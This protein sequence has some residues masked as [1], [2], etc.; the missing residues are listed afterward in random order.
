MFHELFFEM[1]RRPPHSARSSLL[2]KFGE[3]VVGRVNKP[4]CGNLFV[5]P[6]K[7]MFLKGSCQ[8]IEHLVCK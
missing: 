2:L 1:D 4:A 6:H 5:V 3:E 7:I 8:R